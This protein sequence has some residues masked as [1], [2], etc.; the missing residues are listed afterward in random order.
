MRDEIF[1]DTCT[2]HINEDNGHLQDKLLQEL[3][4][5]MTHLP[6]SLP[7]YWCELNPRKLVFQ[8][9]L[10]RLDSERRRH[11]AT[12]NDI[13]FDGIDGKMGRFTCKDVKSSFIKCG[14]HKII[15]VILH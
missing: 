14:M 15:M 3:G 4:V 7:P 11:N 6:P 2:V 12:S 10:A 13:F 1:V 5:L 8:T 9:L